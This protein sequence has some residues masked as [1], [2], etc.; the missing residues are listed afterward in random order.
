MVRVIC[1]VGYPGS[2][3]SVAGE[4]A[5][6]EFDV[7]AVEMGN[8]VRERAE[9]ECADLLAADGQSESIETWLQMGEPLREE[10]RD[11]DGKL[12]LSRSNVI[13]SW[14]TVQR[15]LH[16]DEVVA[17]WTAEYIDEN[18]DADT[19]LVDGVRSCEEYEVFAESFEDVEVVHIS[20]PFDT[21]LE[22][23]QERG[24]DGEDEFTTTDLK[25]RDAREEDWGVEEIVERADVTVENTGTLEEYKADLRETLFT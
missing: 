14:A 23:L 2:G 9:V 3:K 19:V 20:T 17:K 10:L 5:D 15:D 6:S 22:R 13:G 11:D 21:R 4:V 24:R 16:G 7:P 1:V 8:R 25:D 18:V 12:D